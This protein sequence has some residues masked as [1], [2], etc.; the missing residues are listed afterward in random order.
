MSE[1]LVRDMVPELRSPLTALNLE[2]NPFSDPPFEETLRLDQLRHYHPLSICQKLAPTLE[3]MKCRFC[4]IHIV[5]Y[6]PFPT[7]P[8]VRYLK[9]DDDQPRLMPWIDACPNVRHLSSFTLRGEWPDIDEEGEEI[10]DETRERNLSDQRAHGSWEH[11]EEYTGSSVLELY[12]L[13]L[14]CR[15]PKLSIG[16]IKAIDLASLRLNAVLAEARPIHFAF[17]PE[18]LPSIFEGEHGIVALL[19]EPGA[20]Y[21]E[22][23]ELQLPDWAILEDGY[24]TDFEPILRKLLDAIAGLPQ[25]STLELTFHKPYLLEVRQV[26]G[27]L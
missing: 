10:W 23:L 14:T 2:Y 13:G 5:D 24:A 26:V 3:R 12:L 18:R 1:K 9:L 25:L 17:A 4:T 19:R 8:N 16:T 20:S 7:Y 27:G 15:I 21:I 6:A 22:T 11:L